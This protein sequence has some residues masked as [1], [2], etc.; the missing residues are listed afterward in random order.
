MAR[1][2]G[3]INKK[4][5]LMELDGFESMTS[6]SPLIASGKELGKITSI[7]KGIN[8]KILALG[9]VKK[10]LWEVGKNVDCCTDGQQFN[11]T[12]LPFAN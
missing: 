8:G 3:Q 6:G 2:R 12:V 5:V 7:C 10:E 11:V 1:D 9:F 4:L